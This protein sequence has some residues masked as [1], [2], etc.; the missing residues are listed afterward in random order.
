MEPDNPT[1]PPTEDIHVHIKGDVSGQVGIGQTVVQFDDG[2]GG[3]RRP[4]GPVGAADAMVA[5]AA[6]L[7]D[8]ES[9]TPFSLG[10]SAGFAIPSSF[11]W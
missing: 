9:R 2:S 4:L 6:G 8:R 10:K 11:N 1:L 3:R 5:P 7:T